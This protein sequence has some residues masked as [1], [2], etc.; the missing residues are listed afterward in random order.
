VRPARPSDRLRINATFPANHW[1]DNTDGFLGFS[2]PSET[3]L[4]AAASV[5]AE[6]G[7]TFLLANHGSPAALPVLGSLIERARSRALTTLI[8]L[9]EIPS[10]DPREAALHSAGF[11]VFGE[12]TLW[13]LPVAAMLRRARRMKPATG[14]WTW[15]PVTP[16]DIARWL[17]R[18]ETR[19][20]LSPDVEFA[21]DLSVAVEKEGQPAGLVL[22]KRIDRVA[23]LNLL[24][25]S[26]EVRAVGG[27]IEPL[28]MRGPLSLHLAGI[29]EI[30]FT[31]DDTRREAVAFARRCDGISLRKNLRFRLAL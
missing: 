26:D 13:K 22:I 30:I 3:R 9:N 20:L 6:G 21:P 18:P 29:K 11:Q 10:G 12:V 8:N 16:A 1:P 5:N 28:L 24:V 15:R 14:R 23:V 4:L 2:D 19:A 17:V 31:T 7:L 27:G 25:V